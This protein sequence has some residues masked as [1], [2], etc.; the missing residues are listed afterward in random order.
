M[1]R[2]IT[3][4]YDDSLRGGI[5]NV[6]AI[7]REFFPEMHFHS[8]NK[9]QRNMVAYAWYSVRA[10][11]VFFGLVLR[12]K[13]RLVHIH[14]GSRWDCIRHIPYILF[15]RS[16][17]VRVLLHFRGNLDGGFFRHI[18]PVRAI[19]KWAFCLADLLVF[20]TSCLERDFHRRVRQVRSLVIPDPIT[21]NYLDLPVEP[22]ESRDHRVLFMGRYNMDKGIT[23]LVAAARMHVAE[24]DSIVYE[25]HG[26]GPV[27]EDP[28]ERTEWLGWVKDPEKR[29]CYRTAKLLVLPSYTEGFP[30]CVVEAMTCGT[31]VVATRVGGIPDMVR[32]GIHGLLVE[33]HDAPALYEALK[34]LVTDKALWTT[35]SQNCRRDV[36]QYRV[37][38]V[39]KMWEVVYDVLGDH[40]IGRSEFQKGITARWSNL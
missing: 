33:P 28:P 32:D 31:P 6:N 36:A 21:G 12:E 2:I 39:C 29:E 4:T 30:S 20:Q 22:V 24:D 18:L 38:R 26:E 9:A 25:A 1:A 7:F 10:W 15:S 16:V 8:A 40:R 19:I 14:T 34:R 5:T 13:P 11:F 37:T 27:P 3:V 23:E 35:C 17:G